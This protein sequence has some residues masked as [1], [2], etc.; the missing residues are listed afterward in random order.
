MAWDTE[1]TKRKIKDAATAEF[2]RYGPA[3]TTIER[4][5]KRAGVNKERVYNYFGSKDRLFSAVLRDE[6]TKAAEAV[7]P[8]FDEGEAVGAYAGRLSDYHR[9]RPELIRLLCWEALTFDDEVPE[10]ELRREHYQRKIAGMRSGQDSGALTRDVDPGA[11]MLMIMS[12]TGWWSTAPQV[13]RM[14]CGPL[15]EEEH[16]RRRAIVVEAA[17]RLAAPRE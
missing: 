9:Q 7:P 10:E 5:A 8:A 11:L 13:A 14:L 2:T 16:D 17:R 3:G 15:D 12:L 4:I 6:L 1:G